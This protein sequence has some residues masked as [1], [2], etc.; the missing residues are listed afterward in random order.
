MKSAPGVPFTGSLRTMFSG[1]RRVYIPQD[2]ELQVGRWFDSTRCL[3][4]LFWTS[5]ST[6]FFFPFLRGRSTSRLFCQGRGALYLGVAAGVAER[7]AGDQA[8]V[9]THAFITGQ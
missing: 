7:A 1:T 8:R 6:G 5:G 2:W 3:F 9:Y 4:I